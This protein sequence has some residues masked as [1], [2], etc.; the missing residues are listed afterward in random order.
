MHS[1]QLIAFWTFA[2]NA[3]IH[4][5][6]HTEVMSEDST[7]RGLQPTRHLRTGRATFGASSP[8]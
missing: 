2:A 5:M 6:R 1:V 8:G 7:K 3:A 4:I